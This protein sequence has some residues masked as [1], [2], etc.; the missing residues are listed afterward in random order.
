MLLAGCSEAGKR[1]DLVFLNG[2]E[3]ESLDPAVITGQ[4]E[5]RLVNALFEGLTRFTERGLAEPGVAESWAISPDGRTYTFRLRE[6]ARWSDGRPV[7]AGD[8]VASWRRTLSPETAA[9]YNYQL[10][11]VKNA[12]AFAEGKLADFSA[13]GV[14]ARDPRTLEVELES[15][16]PFFLE[17]CATPPLQPVRVDVIERHGDNWVKPGHLVGNGAY[18]LED[19]RIND[20]VRLRKNPAYWDAANVALETV[21]ALPTSK[22]NVAFNLYASGEADLL[23]D[24]GLVP[25]A[26]LDAL[27]GRPDFHSGPFFATYFLRFNAAR[28]PFRDE[29]VRRAFSLAVD[30]ERIVKKITRAGELPAAAL[31]PPGI[32]GYVS[33]PGLAYDPAEARRLLAEAG[34][35]GGKGLPLLRYLYAESELNEA[36]A[37]ELQSMWSEALGVQVSLTRQEWKVYLNSMNNLDFDICRSSWVGDYPDPNTF[38]DLFVTGGGNNRTGWGDPAYDALIADAGRETDP[39]RRFAILAQAEEMLVARQA[40]VCPLYFYVGIQLYDPARLTGIEANLIDEHPIRLM[41]RH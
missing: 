4:P 3:P 34:F 8:F 37:V 5:G 22:A 28:G 14:R 35:P 2:A 36:I 27:R 38:L 40:V 17:L 23:L 10:F 39:A 9:A 15:P 26:L 33:P 12:K 7:T 6:N 16:T 31:V 18:V 25:P 41:R 13:V 20:R 21:D 30:K 19:W 11:Y 24:K 32:V 1:A 29:R